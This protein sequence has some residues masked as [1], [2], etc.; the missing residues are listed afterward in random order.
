MEG[1]LKTKNRTTYDPTAPLLGVNPE[2]TIIQKEPCTPM[3]IAV[4]FTIARTW[5]KPRC[6][7]TEECKEKIRCISTVG[8]YLAIKRNR[9]IPFAATWVDPE[10]YSER[11]K[12]DTERQ[13]SH[14]ITYMWTLRKGYK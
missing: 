14:D 6:P 13:I 5:K 11:S 8:Y 9:I 1:P 4:L 2:K 10:T 12:P 7:S 3:F